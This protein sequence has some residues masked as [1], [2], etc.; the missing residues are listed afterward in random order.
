MSPAVRA[1]ACWVA[2]TAVLTYGL[3][4]SF[5]VYTAELDKPDPLLWTMFA[6]HVMRMFFAVRYDWHQQ[7]LKEVG[8]L[9]IAAVAGVWLAMLLRSF[10]L[11]G[12]R[13]FEEQPELAEMAGAYAEYLV[14][15]HSKVFGIPAFYLLGYALSISAIRL[16]GTKWRLLAYP[17]SR[18][19]LFG[20]FYSAAYAELEPKVMDPLENLAKAELA[21]TKGIYQ[22]PSPNRLI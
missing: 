18:L 21:E 9:S 4:H 16:V 10:A 11:E 14:V 3:Y 5:L 2:V 17:R 15:I 19:E 12:V 7:S 6:A 8:L 20:A 13:I 22:T 1:Q